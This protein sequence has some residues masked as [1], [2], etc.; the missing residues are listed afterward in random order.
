MKLLIKFALRH[1]LAGSAVGFLVLVMLYLL[2]RHPFLIPVIFDFRWLLLSCL[3]FLALRSFRDSRQGI[4]FFWQ[5]MAGGFFF[6]L[7]F[8]MAVSI[9]LLLFGI[10]Q[11]DFFKF[12][13]VNCYVNALTLQFKKNEKVIIER[14]GSEVFHQQLA[15][16]PHTA[17][18]DLASDY[19]LKSMLIGLFLSL[20]FSIIL[21]KQPKF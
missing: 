21:R 20:I 16:L 10:F 3:L 15:K 12:V 14:V 19:F 17:A 7:F 2:G 6:H 13:F 4:L 9:A 1:A 11:P 8:G 5:G 18:F